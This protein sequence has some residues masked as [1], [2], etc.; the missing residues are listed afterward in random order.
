MMEDKNQMAHQDPVDQED[1]VETDVRPLEEREK[2]AVK[3]ELIETEQPV[4]YE[5][6]AEYICRWGAARASVIVMTPFLGSLALMANEVYM[7]TRLS[8]LYG[9]ELETGAI[10]GLIG[11]LGASFVGQTLF[12]LIPFPPLQVPMAVAITYGVGKAADA[13]LKAG[14]PKDMDRIKEIFEA[15]R[16]EGIAR[17]KE[18][19]ED[20]T[21]NLP[22]GDETK[23]MMKEKAGPLFDKIK[24][25][26]DT[27]TDKVTAAVEDIRSSKE[28]PKGK[29]ASAMDAASDV[30]EQARLALQPY[31][32]M[33][34]RWIEAPDLG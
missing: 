32:E 11:S 21:R 26:A 3:G 8:D 13:W 12:T 18:F 24:N 10:A 23:D 14:Q 2:E 17:F 31:K 29:L 1:L 22:L 5:K 6:E 4:D 28:G 27:A 19:K 20:P 30:A 16:K 33:A 34:L 15:A 7:I 25:A 9:V